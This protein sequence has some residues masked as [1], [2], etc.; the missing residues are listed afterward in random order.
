MR[1][2]I[3]RMRSWL[4]ERPCPTNSDRPTEGGEA[5]LLG[6]PPN[7]HGQWGRKG[8]KNWFKQRYGRLPTWIEAEFCRMNKGKPAA[9]LAIFWKKFNLPH[10]EELDSIVVMEAFQLYI[11]LQ[12]AG[13]GDAMALCKCN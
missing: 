1:W 12:E 5:S 4:G 6:A 2:C 10:P 9:K 3:G 7:C 13:Y 8:F 11:D